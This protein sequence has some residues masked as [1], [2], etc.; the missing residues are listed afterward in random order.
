MR[1]DATA[2]LCR[3]ATGRPSIPHISVIE[4]RSAFR[5]ERPILWAEG[6]APVVSPIAGLALLMASDIPGA[7]CRVKAGR[8]RRMPPGWDMWPLQGLPPAPLVV[9]NWPEM[10]ASGCVPQN[11]LH[12]SYLKI[13][14]MSPEYPSLALPE[15]LH[16]GTLNPL[17]RSAGLYSR[18]NIRSM[19][20]YDNI[21]QN[22]NVLKD[23]GVDR[24]AI[25]AQARQA[26][27]FAKSL[28][29]P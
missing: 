20:A 26:R 22:I 3:S 2:K 5:E 29:C 15:G 19:S 24:S 11:S 25:A 16:Q 18:S 8:R 28:P 23:A 1:P 27:S 13:Y 9:R 4:R 7:S 21:R 14:M 17:Q 10:G 12:K 6:H